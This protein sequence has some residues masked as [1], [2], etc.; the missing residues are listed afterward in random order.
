MVKN[1]FLIILITFNYSISGYAWVYPEHRDITLTAIRELDPMHR[2]ILDRLW[3]EARTGYE[4]RLD[5]LVIDPSQGIRP[6]YI[7]FAAWPAIAGDHSTSAENM[8]DNILH[9]DWILNVVNVAALLKDGLA[10]SENRSDRNNQ[11]R[12]SDIRLLR[13]DP[14]YVS[15]AGANNGHFM[16]ARPDIN[17]SADTYFRACIKPGCEPNLIGIYIWFHTSAINK[18][19]R[20]STEILTAK[21]RSALALAALAD[22]AFA[23]HFL[24]DGF[25]SGHV[26][27]C[28][29]NAA[30]RKGSHDYYNEK[31]IEVRTWQGEALV[32]MGDA[33]MRPEDS[34]RAANTIRM[35]LE[36]I[37]DAAVNKNTSQFYNDEPA[38][39]FA[40][41]FN[42]GTAEHMPLRKTDTSYNSLLYSVL[43][44]TPIPGLSS[45]PGELPRF[46]SEIGPFAGILASGRGSVITNGFSPSQTTAGIVGGFEMAFR[47]GYGLDGVLNDSGDGLIFI[48]AGWRLDGA[49]TMK[50]ANDPSLA[51]FKTISA[52]IP[53]RSALSLRL[54]MPFWLIPGD[55]LI[56]TPILYL[57]SKKSLKKMLVS[58]GNGGLIPWQS[59]IS[60]GI[61]R[62]RFILGREVGVSFFGAGFSDG[63]AFNMPVNNA[64]QDGKMI[65]TMTST[66]LDFPILEYRPFHFYSSNQ[67]GSLMFQLNAGVD[68]PGDVTVVY[69]VNATIPDVRPTWF[70]G[71]RLAFDWRHYLSK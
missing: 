45:G 52:A 22:E 58:A 3:A 38:T 19:K 6:K 1:V 50:I 39:F 11:L 69:P 35:S 71:L 20:L 24:E 61:G 54:R 15:R 5:E 41:T 70:V 28:W 42:V 59:G 32:L 63:G 51:Q 23:L 66:Q 31:G 2:A 13:A 10:S 12:N 21:Q 48:D 57:V 26:A 43:M 7:D 67:T 40:D 29:G 55:L 44:T 49:S 37:L 17:T 25:A 16:I 30:Q 36:Q 60:S 62:F 46:R 14:E 33:F 27:G 68:L 9:T 65:I 64:G 18:A 47:A 53:S 34:Q 4:S 8:L 56:A